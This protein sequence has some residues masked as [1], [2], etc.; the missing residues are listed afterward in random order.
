MTM[1]VR[2]SLTALAV[3]ALLSACGGG[4]GG[5][6]S[7][8]SSVP[9]SSSSS[10]T[11]SSASST[12]AVA[13]LGWHAYG[14]NNLGTA[15]TTGGEG[16]TAGKTYTVTNRNE[17]IQALYGNAAT[18]NNDGSVSGTLDS[19]KKIIYVSGTI[20]LN[21]NKALTELTE[22]N[23]VTYATAASCSGAS[24]YGTASA[25][26]TAYYAAFKPSV[27][28]TS[29][30]PIGSN[31]TVSGAPETA[32]ACYATQ[33][34]KVVYVSIPSNTSIIGVGS[35]AKIIN[36]NLVVG[37]SSSSPVDNVVIRNIAFEDAF[38]FFPQWDPTDSSTGRWNSAYDNV[39]VMYATHVL[40]DHNEFSDGSG[41]RYDANY[42]SP[43]NETYAGTDYGSA[44]NAL[45]Y[46]VQHHDGLSD[47]TKNANYVTLSNNYYHDHDKSML[48]GGT[49]TAALAAE[50]PA[51]LKVTFHHNYFKN[52]RQ[53]QPRVRYGMVHVYNNYFKGDTNATNYPFSAAWVAGQGAKLYVENNVVDVTGATASLVYSGSSSTSK[54]TPCAALSGMWTEYC[55]A[56]A[57]GA[58]NV[59][60]GSALDMSSVSTTGVTWS[61]TPWMA[62]GATSGAPTATPSA[63]YSYTLDGTG[64][65]ATTVPANAGVGKI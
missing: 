32:R 42:P 30:Q 53:R 40:I 23:Y 36:G 37:S 60:N 62:P 27:W 1:L 38:D 55:S 5:G 16:A 64:S 33:Q 57:F 35:T 47:V 31:T 4:G 41:T 9:A 49:D 63:Y 22:D 25:M 12:G 2:E 39:S 10:S 59:L 28:G 14:T 44:A 65:L 3:V 26:W 20:S 21:V 43:F 52:L 48:L 11:S 6:S 61:S 56:Y 15:G 50:N 58:G 7:S 54:V 51:A 45:L 24:T 34:K 17:F 29:A 8:A 19:S 13:T 18:I 46:H